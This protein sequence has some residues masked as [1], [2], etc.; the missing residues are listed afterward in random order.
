MNKN[1]IVIISAILSLLT[2]LYLIQPSIYINFLPYQI[3]ESLFR[4]SGYE[5]EFIKAFDFLISVL[6]FFVFKKIGF[7]L[8]KK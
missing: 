2:F 7:N 6:L 4:G 3:H 5:S 8:I 1:I